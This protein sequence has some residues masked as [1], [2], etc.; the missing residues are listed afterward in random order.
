M[1]NLYEIL[2]V[3]EQATQE[4]IKK[5]FREKSKTSHPDKG[6]NEEEFKRINNAYS[7]LS[8]Q[9]KR[10]EYDNQKNNPFGG[11]GGG[12]P[13]D[14]F[15]NFFNQGGFRQQ[16][17]VNDKIVDL[18]VGAVDSF[19]GKNIT[20]NFLRNIKC[21]PC[22]GKGGDRDTCNK[23]NGQGFTVLRTGNSFFANVVRQACGSCGGKGFTFRNKCHVCSGNGTNHEMATISLNLPKGIS[24]G[25]F[26]KAKGYGDYEDGVYGNAILRVNIFEQNGFEKSNE[27]LIYHLEMSL[28]DFEKDNLDIPHPDGILNIKM[29]NEINT[30]QPLRVKKK[31]YNGQGDLYVKM[32]VKHNRNN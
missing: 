29:P 26:I 5:A 25:Q 27:D 24:D 14:M 15:S 1:E 31:G 9:N 10:M 23:C 4:E 19:V 8:D 28:K 30:N 12:D 22:G 20:V 32:F 18:K 2:G 17:V 6:G 13:F 11:F 16:K 7:V 21:E 3:G